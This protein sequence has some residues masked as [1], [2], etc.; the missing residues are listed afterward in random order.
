MQNE[1][2]SSVLVAVILGIM[3]TFGCFYLVYGTTIGTNISSAG[4]LTAG[5]TTIGTTFYFD[6]SGNASTTGAFVAGGAATL[7]GTVSLASTTINNTLNVTG[8]ATLTGAASLNGTVSLAT[9]T[10]NNTLAVTGTTT[11][12][13]G[14]AI[15][16]F[17]FGTVS[18]T[19]PAINTSST[20]LATNTLA[21][22]TADME[23][24]LQAPALLNN[25]L[26]PK[27]C[28]TTAGV[29]GVYLY[30]ASGTIGAGGVNPWGYLLVK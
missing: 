11:L 26:I 22:A 1:K 27:G 23:C 13:S 14:T 17:L 12:G 3:F 4:T 10:V 6:A 9:T 2:Y 7:N 30:N 15:N 29:I 25:Y 24:F 16:K 20:G 28:T 8:A 21:A 5:T 18:L 19:P